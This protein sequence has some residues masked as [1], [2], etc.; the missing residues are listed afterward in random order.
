MTFLMIVP[1]SM[2]AAAALY[3]LPKIIRFKWRPELTKTFSIVAIVGF[4]VLA[5][6][7]SAPLTFSHNQYWADTLHVSNE[8]LSLTAKLDQLLKQNPRAAIYTLETKS[9]LESEFSMAPLEMYSLQDI[10]WKV[11]DPES[12]I[13]LTYGDQFDSP[14]VFLRP[15]DFSILQSSQYTQ[16]Y[17]RNHLET[18]PP[19]IKNDDGA[20]YKIM[21]KTPPSLTQGPALIRPE[22]STINSWMEVADLLSLGGFGYTIYL[23]DDPA[24][25]HQSSFI[26]VG[27]LSQLSKLPS[28]SDILWVNVDGNAQPDTNIIKKEAMLTLK[29]VSLDGTSYVSVPPFT[30]VAHES[31]VSVGLGSAFAQISAA[32]SD[33]TERLVNDSSYSKWQVGAWGSGTIGIPQ[34][35]SR[36]FRKNRKYT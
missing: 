36:Q 8:A 12:A 31:E 10:F 15:A 32:K 34:I 2:L 25:N 6:F 3:E 29:D 22:S 18:F 14:Y 16:S 1:L 11:R 5:G 35:S 24:T 23:E 19:L 7:S 9:R 20:I 4:V 21:T 27:D 28:G 30:T 26:I 13:R 17:I 33:Y